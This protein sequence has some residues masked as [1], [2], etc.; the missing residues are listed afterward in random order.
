MKNIIITLILVTGITVTAKSQVISQL[1]IRPESPT[2]KDTISVISNFTFY[3][4]CS[5]GLVDYNTHLDGSTIQI[6]PFYCG[7]ADPTLCNSVDTFKLGPFPTG[8]Y[9]I[10]IE[11]HQ[12]SICPISDFDQ[13]ISQ[14]DTSVIIGTSNIWGNPH[15]NNHIKIYPNPTDNNLV[16]D[17]RNIPQ[18]PDCLLKIVN[19]TGK[20]VLLRSINQKRID[21]SLSDWASGIYFVSLSDRQGKTLDYRKLVIK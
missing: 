15:V 7:Y 10:N 2:E 6:T 8:L 14:Y 9:N 11:Y 16:I 1:I 5:F 17:L 3:G 4:N 19:F 18:R 20:E 13:I 12:G 21:I